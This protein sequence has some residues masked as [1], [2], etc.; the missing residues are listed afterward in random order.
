VGESGKG[1]I[2]LSEWHSNLGIPEFEQLS[3]DY[4]KRYGEDFFHWK[5]ALTLYMLSKAMT[6]AKSVD[7]LKVAYALE[8]LR[9]ETPV[10]EAWM[11]KEDHQIIEPLFISVLTDGQKFDIDH[12]G[13]GLKT[14]RKVTARDAEVATTCKMERPAH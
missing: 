11:R 13:L 2:F 8:G 4:E 10:G 6:E 1:L 14:L 7:P 12:T 5:I 3:K 9:Y